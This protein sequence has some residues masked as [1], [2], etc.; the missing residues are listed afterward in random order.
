LSRGLALLLTSNV[1]VALRRIGL[2]KAVIERAVALEQILQTD[3]SETPKAQH[4]L[5]PSNER[6]A[7]NVGIMRGALMAGICAMRSQIRYST[8]IASLDSSAKTYERDTARIGPR[9]GS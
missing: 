6:Y 4:D 1:G 2:E 8:T 3:V 5:C 7:P 9:R